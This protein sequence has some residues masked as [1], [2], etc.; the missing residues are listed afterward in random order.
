MPLRL[1]KFKMIKL[2]SY[3]K[4][5]DT[6][7]ITCPAGYM[8]AEKA[9]TCIETL[10]QWGYKIKVGATLGSTS[11]T[12]FSG[13]DEERL[14]DFQ[15]LLDDDTVKAILCGRGGYGVTRIIEQINF[16]AFKKNPKWIIGFSD[17][18]VLHSHIYSNYKIASLHAPMA[19]AFNNGAFNNVYVQSLRHALEGKKIKYELPAHD[20]NVKGAAIG[21]L[22][23]G[24]LS[25]LAHSIGTASDIKT[26]GRILFLEDVGEYLYSTD[27]M[28]QQ[29]IRSGKLEKL[30]GLIVGGFTDT[31]D[32]ERPFGKTVYEIIKDAVASYN[33]P[34]CY[35]FPVSH[36]KENYALK[37]G[38][39]YKLKVGKTKVLLEE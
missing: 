6:I 25:L 34:V 36:E 39:G 19:A 9:Q 20:F 3:L 32:T 26:R 33:Y 37:V 12:Y 11:T 2:P 17:I 1:K 10:T 8:A 22:V 30:A 35:N 16:K 29:L 28:M 38:V 13:T 15:Q 31:K 21:E 14:N 27:R 7:G 23:G 5:G 18:T 24:N 4:P